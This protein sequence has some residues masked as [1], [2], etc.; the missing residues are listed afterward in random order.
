[1]S[2]KALNAAR[3]HLTEAGLP[4]ALL[5]DTLTDFSI[6]PATGQFQ[7]RLSRQTVLSPGG[8]TVTYAPALK[9]RLQP[10]LLDQLEGVTV[11]V[12]FFHPAITRIEASADRQTITFHV[13]G[14]QHQVPASAF[15]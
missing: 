7:V 4:A 1:M 2:D 6:D 12:G 5:P 10:G 11:K 14:T 3:A 8:H 15:A 13:M 9:G